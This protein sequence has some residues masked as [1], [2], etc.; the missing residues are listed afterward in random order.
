MQQDT[1]SAMEMTDGQLQL[2][3]VQIETKQVVYTQSMI[4]TQSQPQYP[5]PPPPPSNPQINIVVQNAPYQPPP[6]PQEII[7]VGNTAVLC[8]QT[9]FPILM[10][11]PYCSKLGTTRINFQPGAGTWICCFI[12]LL[13]V[14]ICCW[15]PFVSDNCQD[16]NHMCPNCGQLVG[17]C[18]YKVCE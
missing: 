2:Q 3:P 10:T 14:W 8:T 13:L 4:T 11:C 15:I 7:V 12:L 1:N 17:T 6:P 16:A 5:P 18:I 9:R